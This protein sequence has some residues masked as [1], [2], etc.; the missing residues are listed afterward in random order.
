MRDRAV[1]PVDRI[2]LVGGRLCLDF[3]N[4]ANRLNG[5]ACDERFNDYDDVLRWSAR[6][7]LIDRSSVQALRQRASESPRRAKSAL[8]S[9]LRLRHCLWR[10]FS[11]QRR[12]DDLDELRRATKRSPGPRLKFASKG[13]VFIEPGADLSGWLL[14]TVSASA[15]ELLTANDGAK[16]KV[17]PGDRCGWLFLDKGPGAGRKWCS[18]DSRGAAEPTAPYIRVILARAFGR[19]DV[20]I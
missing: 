20:K 3:A 15:I 8:E 6:L 12:S 19:R 4:T 2:A 1:P 13:R 9:V 5:A 7:G 11:A 10:V 17:C 14:R 18:P 16:V